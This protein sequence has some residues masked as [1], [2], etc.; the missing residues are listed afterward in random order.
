MSNSDHTSKKHYHILDLIKI[1]AAYMVVF[2]HVSF[3]GWFGEIMICLARFSVPLFF[4]I[5]GYFSYSS[6]NVCDKYRLKRKIKYTACLFIG[7]ICFYVLAISC[8]LR[9][10]GKIMSWL[11]N[12]KYS[13]AILRFILWNK[14]PVIEMEHLWFLGA[15]LYCYIFEYV[16]CKRKTVF[17]I[18]PVLFLINFLFGE[19]KSILGVSE[20]PVY[21]TRNAW[22]CGLPCFTTGYLIREKNIQISVKS[23]RLLNFAL[24][25]EAMV[26]VE[27]SIVGNADLYLFSLIAAVLLF[28]FGITASYDIGP[29]GK[30]VE[31]I[32]TSMIYVLH[33]IVAVVL[34]IMIEKIRLST[35]L[36][37]LPVMTCCVVTA[38]SIIVCIAKEQLNRI[39]IGRKREEK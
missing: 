20:I 13:D 35:I 36:A 12:V 15:L 37:L 18:L 6:I 31:K 7:S 2:I 30:M 21:F 26:L 24:L 39:L 34:R 22:F 1:I 4:I 28:L 16:F 23:S 33:P 9:S 10:P 29:V 25:A 11:E 38:I 27:A 8:V 5:S 14:L 19:F 17:K 3:P 32:D